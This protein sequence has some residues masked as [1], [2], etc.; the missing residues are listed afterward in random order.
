MDT[1]R[2]VLSH[3]EWEYVVLGGGEPTLHPHFW[4]ILGLSLGHAESVWLATNGSQTKIA[5]ALAKMARKGVIGCALSLDPYHDPIAP[6]VETAFQEG[7]PSNDELN[8]RY[9]AGQHYDCR[10]IRTAR[11][12]FNQGRC[13]FGEDDECC[14]GD[15]LIRPDGQVM[16]CQCLDSPSIGNVWDG[17]EPIMPTEDTAPYICH[18]LLELET[19]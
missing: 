18:S 6:A 15:P 14:Y 5:L 12:L 10:E 2:A 9:D 11:R 7:M 16:Q 1:F 13:D 19:V 4:K 3:M 17:W 8:R